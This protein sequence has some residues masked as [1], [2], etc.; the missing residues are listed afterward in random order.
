MKINT[1]GKLFF[2]AL[3]ANVVLE[4]VK[5]ATASSAVDDEFTEPEVRAMMAAAA[6]NDYPAFEDH[7]MLRRPEASDSEIAEMY[8]K[9]VARLARR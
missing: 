7:Y 2:G 9:F 1:L 4:G 6:N 3:A 5:R 8:G